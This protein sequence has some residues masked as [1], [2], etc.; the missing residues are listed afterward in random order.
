MKGKDVSQDGE[1][2]KGDMKGIL[3][4]KPR[5]THPDV[6]AARRDSLFGE[7]VTL[8]ARHL[9]VLL[10][11]RVRQGILVMCKKGLPLLCRVQ[12]GFLCKMQV[13]EL[14]L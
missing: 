8:A 9:R 7:N 13:R 6:D 10:M 5:Q 2:G 12:Q 4:G 3:K 1:E 11:F 14:R